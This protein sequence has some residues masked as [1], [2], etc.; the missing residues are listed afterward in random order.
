VVAAQL[1]GI[2]CAGE[3][4]D[5]SGVDAA[6]D[7]TTVDATADLADL[8][9]LADTA[10]TAAQDTTVT[11]DSPRPPADSALGCLPN[12][13]GRITRAEVP[14][15]VGASVLYVV[16]RGGTVVSPVDTVGVVGDGGRLWDY[17]RLRVEDHRVLEEVT[18]AAGQ[19]WAS[20]VPGAEFATAL[21]REQ[22]TLG[23]YRATAGAL[24]LLAAVSV[25]A[26]RTLL[27][28]DP[29]VDVLRFPIAEGNTWTQEVTGR[30]AV[31]FTPLVNV[32][33]Y[34]FRVDAQ[35]EVRTPVG[36][37]P[38]LRVRV[39]L[40]QRIPVTLL[41]RTQRSFVFL[42]ECWGVVARVASVDNEPLVEFT[43]AAEFRRLG[44]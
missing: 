9:D 12:W 18:P 29:A 39:D 7:T 10:D 11:A 21:D 1:L 31:N 35:G 32:T 40:D 30:G 5:P 38:S 3:R 2:G 8:A 25:E 41:R 36:R 26:N 16:N 15:V 20:R 24:Q 28:F 42:T 27:L 33:S 4:V 22:G 37:F 14:F 43:R 6:R 13:D 19:W 23:V 44:L 34:V 17:S